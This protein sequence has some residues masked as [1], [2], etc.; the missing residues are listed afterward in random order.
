VATA[1]GG[2]ARDGTERLGRMGDEAPVTGTSSSAKRYASA[3]FEL[4]TEEGRTEDWRRHLTAI[5]DLVSDPV[6]EDVLENPTISVAQRIELISAPR[7]LDPEA[8]NLVRMLI[9]AGHV[10]LVSGIL[11]EFERLAD[12]AAGRVRAT[13]TTA[14][15]MSTDD[16]DRLGRQLSKRLGKEVRVTVAVDRAIIGGLKLQYGDH[17]IDASLATRLQQL[18]RRLADAS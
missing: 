12:E 14:V 9:E 18:R 8:T 5:R 13:V 17:L 3:V 2:A 7:F 16:R 15:E 4:A 11:D 1:A 10:D 6:V